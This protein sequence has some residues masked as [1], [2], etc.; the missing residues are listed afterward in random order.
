MND[1]I[2]Y[3]DNA[4]TTF[5]K[6][7]CVYDFMNDFYRSCGGNAGRGN[8]NLSITSGKLISET[9]EL[10]KKLLHCSQKKVVFTPSAT[11]A[12]N[13]IIQ[14]L[15]K[16]GKKNIYISPFEHNAVT[17]VLHHF[18]KQNMIIVYPVSYTHLTLP[19]MAVV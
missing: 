19:T 17:R 10:L 18:E 8:H 9:R 4:A 6:P 13:I 1:K 11:F 14:G 15:I 12:L 7:E 2:A 16:S 5:P 3:F